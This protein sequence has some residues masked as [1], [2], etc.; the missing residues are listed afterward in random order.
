M[1]PERCF[2]SLMPPVLPVTPSCL[3]SPP[4]PPRSLPPALPQPPPSRSLP[5]T[6][7]Y[8]PVFPFSCSHSCRC[9]SRH[10]SSS[11]L[12]L[13]L[14]SPLPFLLMFSIQRHLPLP[15]RHKQC[16]FLLTMHLCPSVPPAAHSGDV[17]CAI[18]GSQASRRRH[19]LGHVQGPL[20][21]RRRLQA[22]HERADGG[23]H[24]Q[25]RL[26][27]LVCP[28][29]LPWDNLPP[30]S[31]PLMIPA[32]PPSSR[33]LDPP[34]PSR[35]CSYRCSLISPEFLS[36]LRCC[37]RRRVESTVLLCLAGT[38][39]SPQACRCGE[40]GG[41]PESHCYSVSVAFSP[42]HYISCLLPVPR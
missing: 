33:V 1:P 25:G 11:A 15:F 12:L 10:S 20:P 28:P 29:P 5:P 26:H 36:P 41:L 21:P 9:P 42:Q 4:P 40:G 6:T 31:S 17:N 3:F 24:L 2:L 8:P 38:R 13:L 35:A 7:P 32:H 14:L 37:G 39:P 23:T 16:F 34:L 27:I 19:V 18:L 30:A 22:E